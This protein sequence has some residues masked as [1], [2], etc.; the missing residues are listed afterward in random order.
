MS[1][2]GSALDSEGLTPSP[3][4]ISEAAPDTA[5]TATETVN[6]GTGGDVD[7]DDVD[8]DDE[9]EDEDQDAEDEEEDDED[10]SV[11]NFPPAREAAV[12]SH[13][14]LPGTKQH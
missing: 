3:M 7:G 10:D 2:P 1:A 4:S 6:N 13:L 9:E 8:D 12:E 5:N 11:F 14:Q